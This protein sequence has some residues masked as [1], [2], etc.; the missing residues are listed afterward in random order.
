MCLCVVIIKLQDYLEINMT[1]NI[2]IYPLLL[3]SDVFD[4]PGRYIYIYSGNTKGEVSQYHC[5]VDLLFDWFGRQL[6]I[7]V[8]ICKTD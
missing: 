6:T 8:F 2:D 3:I 7:F 5:T 1:H 4:P